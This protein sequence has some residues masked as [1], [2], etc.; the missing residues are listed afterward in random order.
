MSDDLSKRIEKA[1][2]M[3][4]GPYN[5]AQAVA[6][7]YADTIGMEEDEIRRLVSGFG[8]GM[9]GERSVCG[10]LSGGIFVL[11]ST[12]R[13]PASREEL[14]DRVFYLISQFKKHNDG[15]LDCLDLVGREP[16]D[17]EFTTICPVLVETMVRLVAKSL[18][19]KS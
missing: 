12:V 2:Q 10:A 14:Y 16:G 11:S 3:F 19:K 18:P 1:R 15:R 8:Y 7:V 5:C 4:A 6:S 17:K 9:A 13:D